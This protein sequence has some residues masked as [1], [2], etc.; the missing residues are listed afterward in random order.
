MSRLTVDPRLISSFKEMANN[1]LSAAD[2]LE[3]G[4][5]LE[6]VDPC[7]NLLRRVS[8][9]FDETPTLERQH[10]VATASQIE[11]DAKSHPLGVLVLK[12]LRL[13]ASWSGTL[14]DLETASSEFGDPVPIDPAMISARHWFRRG[15]SFAGAAVFLDENGNLQLQRQQWF[16]LKGQRK[17]SID[18]PRAATRSTLVTLLRGSWISR[19]I[20]PDLCIYCQHGPFEEI[21]HFVPRARGGSDD[22]SNL[23]PSCIKCNRGATV[24]KWDKDPWEWLRQHH[25]KR[26]PYFE[27]L[28][29][30][31]GDEN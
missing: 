29:G 18:I 9:F 30:V 6:T 11:E 7:G 15:L 19:S 8:D 13:S 16:S 4:A 20:D 22:F 3:N 21:E 26:L 23:F 24:G 27:R 1:L 17:P 2:A 5:S 12:V 28:F 31:E 25:K 10:Q 14:Q